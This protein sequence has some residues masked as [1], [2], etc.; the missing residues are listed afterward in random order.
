MVVMDERILAARDA[1]K[2]FAR[3][4]GFEAGEMGLLGVVAAHGV[5]FF[6]APVRRH[7]M[8]AEFDLSLVTDLPAVDIRYSYAGASGND[9]GEKVKGVVVATTGFTPAER[10]FYENLHQKGIVVA[11]T[12]PSGENVG[13]PSSPKDKDSNVVAVERLTPLHARIL[14]MVALTKTNDPVEIQRIFREY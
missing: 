5:E 13:S 7:T 8:N 2:M 3:S 14:L 12:F 11:S 6:Y 1:E 9:I 4:G 10:T